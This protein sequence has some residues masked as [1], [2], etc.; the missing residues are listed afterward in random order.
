VLFHDPLFRAL[1]ALWILKGLSTTSKFT[2]SQNTMSS[3]QLHPCCTVADGVGL[4]KCS[5]SAFWGET[6]WRMLWPGRNVESMIEAV[7]A[8]TPHNLL[9]YRDVRRHQKVVDAAS[10]EI[11]GYAR[12][13]LPESHSGKWL[14]AQ[15]PDVDNA[16]R[17][18]LEKQFS[19]TMFK[20]RDDMDDPD[21]HVHEWRRKYKGD[22]NVMGIDSSDQ[23]IDNTY[24]HV[25]YV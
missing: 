13:V 16:T 2:T 25:D 3:Y 22:K 1:G 20:Y 19:E 6:W 14:E 18:R 8:R 24:N 11:V 12:W 5:A 17:E 21:N 4:G 10:G 7:G 9:Q 23:P 15:T